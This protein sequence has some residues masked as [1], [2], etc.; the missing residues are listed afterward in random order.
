VIV[1]I[2]SCS[3]L[4]DRRAYTLASWRKLPVAVCTGL[5]SQWRR[6]RRRNN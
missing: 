5:K 4:L 3:V 6:E 1:A 2:A